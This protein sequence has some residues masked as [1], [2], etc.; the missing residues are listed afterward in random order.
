[1]L[2]IAVASGVRPPRSYYRRSYYSAVAP[3]SSTVPGPIRLGPSGYL[4]SDLQTNESKHRPISKKYP[5]KSQYRPYGSVS[6]PEGPSY[7][8]PKFK[9]HFVKKSKKGYQKF[10]KALSKIR[11]VL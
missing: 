7:F 6:L 10:K 8:N 1:M 5:K 4:R 2:L 11:R 9:I 3:G